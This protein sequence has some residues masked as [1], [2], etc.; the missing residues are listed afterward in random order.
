MFLVAG[1]AAAATPQIKSALTKLVRALPETFRDNAEAAA[2][3][4]VVD[5]NRWGQ[6]RRGH[7]LRHLEAL[8][9][10]VIGG[11]QVRL[12]YRARNG[13]VTT[14]VV[15]PLGLV[16]KSTVWYLVAATDTGLRTFRVDRVSGL[17]ATGEPV[18]RPADFDLQQAWEEIVA[19][20]DV[21]RSPVRVDALVDPDVLPVLRWI[22]ERQLDIGLPLSDGRLPVSVG[23][24][25]P[26]VIAA[27][28]AGFGGKVEVRAPALA[29]AYLARVGTELGALYGGEVVLPP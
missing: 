2:A 14:R 28:L 25:N 13:E 4:V 26:E 18:V 23:G 24:Q 16:T 6:T 9:A 12:G 15:H 27:Q 20:V 5:T 10:A 19:T 8:Q 1:P 17:E 21:L 11:H 22:F 7:R 29:R 3:S